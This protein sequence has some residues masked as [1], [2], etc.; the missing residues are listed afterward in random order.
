MKD[1]KTF[2]YDELWDKQEEKIR[3]ELVEELPRGY[4]R[5]GIKGKY[6]KIKGYVSKNRIKRSY[7]K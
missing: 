5:K 3:E 7:K 4:S 2:N 6:I 1:E